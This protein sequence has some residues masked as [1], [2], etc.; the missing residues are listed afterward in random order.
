MPAQSMQTNKYM[1]VMSLPTT[2]SSGF[3]RL[4]SFVSICILLQRWRRA[5]ELVQR[6]IT[7]SAGLESPPGKL[8][9]ERQTVR[10]CSGRPCSQVTLPREFLPYLGFSQLA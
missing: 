4:F 5:V 1:H 8:S 6:C 3:F 2:L 7:T 10:T 9:Y